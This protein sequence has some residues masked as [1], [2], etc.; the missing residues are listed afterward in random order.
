MYNLIKKTNMKNILKYLVLLFGVA[1]FATSC[2]NDPVDYAWPE[3]ESGLKLWFSESAT[4][5]YELAEN[6]SSISFYLYR[7]QTDNALE[8][9]INVECVTDEAY[10]ED[11]EGN[12]ACIFE[13]PTTAKF[14]AGS[15]AAQVRVLFTFS[16][17]EPEREYEFELAVADEENNSLY[18]A[19]E[20]EFSIASYPAWEDAG[21]GTFDNPTMGLFGWPTFVEYMPIQHKAGTNLYRLPRYNAYWMESNMQALIDDGTFAD[22]AAFNEE[23]EWQHSNSQHIVFQINDSNKSDGGN[24]WDFSNKAEGVQDDEASF[25]YGG[26]ISDYFH[27]HGYM[28][29]TKNFQSGYKNYCTFY[30]DS[31]V[32]RKFYITYI[33]MYRGSAYNFANWVFD[34][35]ENPFYTGDSWEI[36]TDFNADFEYIAG[37]KV[38]FTPA[39]FPE[40]GTYDVEMLSASNKEDLFYLADAF[41]VEGYGL[42]VFV[43]DDKV[44]IPADQPTGRVQNGMMVYAGP[45]GASMIDVDGNL[46]LSLEY[47]MIE[48][49]T[50]MPE[51]GA[52]ELP[53]QPDGEQVVPAVDPDDD[54]FEWPSGVVGKGERYE[55]VEAEETPDAPAADPEPIVTT[56]RISLGTFEE[57]ASTSGYAPA[58]LEDFI[59]EYA[60][61]AEN[62]GP[63]Y[64]GDYAEYYPG[65]AEAVALNVKIEAGEKDDEVI[66]SGLFSN[67]PNG[68]TYFADFAGKDKVVGV[69]NRIGGY[70]MIQPQ[71]LKDKVTVLG[72]EATGKPSVDFAVN[73]APYFVADDAEAGIPVMVVKNGDAIYFMTPSDEYAGKGFTYTFIC[74]YDGGTM[75]NFDLPALPM[76]GLAAEGAAPEMTLTA[77]I[78]E[79]E[80]PARELWGSGD[81]NYFGVASV[82]GMLNKVK[83]TWEITNA[84]YDKIVIDNG[85]AV[86]AEIT[87]GSTSYIVENVNVSPAK[88]NVTAYNGR[89]AVA[90]KSVETDVYLLPNKAAGTWEAKIQ[91]DG[92]VIYGRGWNTTQYATAQC[93]FNVYEVL[94]MATGAL[95]ETPVFSQNIQTNAGSSYSYFLWLNTWRGVQYSDGGNY[96]CHGG[97]GNNWHFD[98][99]NLPTFVKK[100]ADGKWVF[101]GLDPEKTYA[102][103]YTL[104]V[105]PYILNPEDERTEAPSVN[106]NGQTVMKLF[107]KKIMVGG[108]QATMFDAVDLKGLALLNV[109]QPAA[110]EPEPGEGG[111]GGEGT[112]GDGTEGDGQN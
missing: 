19:A 83:L 110:P 17:I 105:W 43:N 78:D 4:T 29:A 69:Y 92:Y 101:S 56:R 111:E 79:G 96:A 97:D 108:A 107:F 28:F 6:Q 89:V 84:E 33:F 103:A 80:K 14:E 1:A 40:L 91:D 52:E 3:E 15:D 64:L 45:S 94:D 31:S 81:T 20:L 74:D 62:Y 93:I 50:I 66:I 22:E 26:L 77:A 54:R 73:F 82:N 75:M 35:K 86:L 112:E 61:E 53:V 11:A 47:Y 46:K 16:E 44:T 55:I 32:D 21:W 99:A 9:P 30:N 37:K 12:A 63:A 98:E 90:Y 104:K 5:A 88:F 18:G 87:D 41:G 23:L 95:S 109:E 67:I 25:L 70:I 100:A 7:N 13:L 72:D 102:V 106:E 48:E 8:V 42:A 10:Y 85:K 51:G 27:G 36:K 76:S 59:G 58:A 60:I 34:W 71:A 68:D 39:G 49:K 65:V 2:T 57:I 24:D 38:A